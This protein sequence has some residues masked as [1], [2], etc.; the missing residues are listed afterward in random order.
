LLEALFMQ[1]SGV[2]LALTWSHRLC[3]LRVLLGM[4]TTAT[5]FPLSKHI[6]GGDTAPTFSGQRVYLQLTWEVV[7]PPSPVEFS[8]HRHFYKLSRS[9]LLGVCHHSCLLPPAYCEGFPLPSSL[10][11][12]APGLLAMCLFCC[13][14]LLLRFFFLFFPGWGL[15][16]P[17][18]YADLAQGCL[19]EYCMLLSSPCG[20]HLPKPFNVKWRCYAQAG[21]VEESKFCLFSVVFSCNVYLQHLSKI[22]L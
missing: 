9:W 12:R 4:T 2:S 13:Y 1:I 15:V 5:S 17:G 14:C 3:L 16:C 21:G 7:F 22:L 11:L 20:L 19:W 8:S 10:L 18:G 6:G